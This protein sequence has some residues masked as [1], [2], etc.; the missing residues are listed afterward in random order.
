MCISLTGHSQH[1]MIK[2]RGHILHTWE[3]SDLSSKCRNKHCAWQ[4]AWSPVSCQT[5][6]KCGWVS[7]RVALPKTFSPPAGWRAWR[8][9]VMTE[10]CPFPLT[11]VSP[12]D[13][14]LRAGIQMPVS[15]LDE[16]GNP[17]S[18]SVHKLKKCWFNVFLDLT[19]VFGRFLS[20]QNKTKNPNHT[21]RCYTAS[22]S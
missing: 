8:G 16:S 5:A 12:C 10:G 3:A 18:S 11:V 21:A 19:G 15:S 20:S 1:R 14:H 13:N 4:K 7:S 6:P 17:P 2:R 9:C 22:I